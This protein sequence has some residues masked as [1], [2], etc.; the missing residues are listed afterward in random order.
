MVVAVVPV[1]NTIQ[2]VVAHT[3][4]VALA[5]AAV[6]AVARTLLVSCFVLVLLRSSLDPAVLLLLDHDLRV[7][8]VM[9]WIPLAGV[10]SSYVMVQW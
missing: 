8:V 3:T 7:L 4:V 5:A 10:V 1:V 2:R 9:V 6:V